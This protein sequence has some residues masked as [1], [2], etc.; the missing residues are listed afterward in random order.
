MIK[1]NY[2]TKDT[3]GKQIVK[4]ADSIGPNIAEGTGLG[5]FADN[6]RFVRVARGSLFETKHWL[7]RIFKRKILTESQ[8]QEIKNLVDEL[9]PKLSTYIKLN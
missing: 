9:N 2:F 8:T 1:W 4:S 3:I 6:K 7:R 5:S